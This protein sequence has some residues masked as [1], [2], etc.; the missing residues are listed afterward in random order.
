MTEYDGQDQAYQDLLD[1]Y[2]AL[3][4]EHRS[5]MA[6]LRRAMYAIDAYRLMA[7]HGFPI[8]EEE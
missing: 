5:A 8:H 2:T 3:A 6:R 1:A 4:N 7:I